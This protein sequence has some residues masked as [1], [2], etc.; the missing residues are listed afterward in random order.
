[1]HHFDFDNSFASGEFRI[2]GLMDGANGLALG[3][4]DG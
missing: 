2:W 1:M 4:P 3:A